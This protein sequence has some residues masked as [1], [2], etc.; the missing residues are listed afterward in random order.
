[1]TKKMFRKLLI[2]SAILLVLSSQAN[3]EDPAYCSA[4]YSAC[5]NEGVDFFNWCINNDPCTYYCMMTCTMSNPESYCNYYCADQ[6][7]YAVES[8]EAIALD[9]LAE[10]EDDYNACMGY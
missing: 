8:C 3:A 10:C 6:C 1:M 9:M 2:I 5:W 4:Q 7:S